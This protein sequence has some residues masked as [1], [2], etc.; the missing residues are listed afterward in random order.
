MTEAEQIADLQEAVCS[1]ADMVSMLA[2]RIDMPSDP[3]LA[4]KEIVMRCVQILQEI[5]PHRG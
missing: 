5:G 1:L 2:A 4:S 3:S